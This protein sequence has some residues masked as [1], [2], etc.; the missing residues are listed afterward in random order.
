MEEKQI[1]AVEH[2]FDKI[3]VAMIRL[4]DVVKIG[5]KIRIKNKVADLVQVVSSMQIDRV[6]AVEAKTGDLISVKVDQRVSKGDAVYKIID[7]A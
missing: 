6:P 3:S 2:F 1:G 7:V 5:D 4:S